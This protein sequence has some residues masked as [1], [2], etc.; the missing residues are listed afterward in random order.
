[1]LNA[2]TALPEFAT[3]PHQPAD[4]PSPAADGNAQWCN[5]TEPLDR[6]VT[7]QSPAAVFNF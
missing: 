1:M 6:G 7:R 5:Y 3:T 2:G 4:L